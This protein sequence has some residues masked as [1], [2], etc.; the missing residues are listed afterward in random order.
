MN[1][2][3]FT[4]DLYLS[5]TGVHSYSNLGDINF[6]PEHFTW[7]YLVNTLY[8][9]ACF[10][11]DHMRSGEHQE[12]TNILKGMRKAASRLETYLKTVEILE[13]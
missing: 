7:E 4:T 11:L 12:L 9:D 6:D 8:E 13:D 10:I 3:N 5:E 2:V 1:S